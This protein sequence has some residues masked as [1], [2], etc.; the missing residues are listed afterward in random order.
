MNTFDPRYREL[1]ETKLKSIINKEATVVSV[2][3]ELAVSRQ[4]IHHWLSRYKRFGISGLVTQKRTGNP[5]AHNRTSAEVE[6]LVANLAQQYFV[7]GVETLHDRLQH[8]HN[9]TLASISNG[10]VTRAVVVTIAGGATVGGE[11]P[12]EIA[13]TLNLHGA[14]ADVVLFVNDLGSL[15]RLIVVDA[16]SLTN[17][18]STATPGAPVAAAEVSASI[19]ARAFT[20]AEPP[21]APGAPTTTAVAAKGASGGAASSPVTTAA[22]AAGVKTPA[23]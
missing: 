16:V 4:T 18:T 13:L 23:P 3:K 22:A 20:T 21:S 11:A 5:V 10:A 1:K 19:N 17:L 12:S 15:S 14:Y 2:A 7:D 6:Q 8:E 9:L